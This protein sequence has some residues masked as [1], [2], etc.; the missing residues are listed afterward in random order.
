MVIAEKKAAWIFAGIFL[1]CFV[2]LSMF[3]Y[4]A[5]HDSYAQA[6]RVAFTDPMGDGLTFEVE[7]DTSSTNFHY[8][9]FSDGRTA[10]E[11]DITVPENGT[12]QFSAENL[13]GKDVS[14][15]GRV[16]IVVENKQGDKREIYKALSTDY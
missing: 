1:L 6:W 4:R 14:L 5:F 11:G 10:G 2:V 7:N 3:E 12:E 8:T 16:R 15:S 13:V 9:V